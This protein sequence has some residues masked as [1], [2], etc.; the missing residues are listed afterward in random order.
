[1]PKCVE[2]IRVYDTGVVN[3]W[4][5]ADAERAS[6]ELAGGMIA[7]TTPSPTTT[8]KPLRKVTVVRGSYLGPDF[9]SAAYIAAEEGGTIGLPDVV[10]DDVPDQQFVSREDRRPWAW[11]ITVEAVPVEGKP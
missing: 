8:T 9:D 6:S 4:E 1:M 11:R 2:V 10:P 7:G 3:R 5:G